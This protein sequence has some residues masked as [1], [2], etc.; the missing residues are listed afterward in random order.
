MELGAVRSSFLAKIRLLARVFNY[1]ES[2]L[3]V[4]R[5]KSL[6][7]CLLGSVGSSFLAKIRL[8][9]RVFNYLESHLAVTRLKSLYMCVLGC[10][11]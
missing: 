1:L 9:A 4:T 11:Y 2:H 10:G 7:M 5:L 6:Y 8:L 3:S